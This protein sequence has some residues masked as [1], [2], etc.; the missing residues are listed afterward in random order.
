[1][2]Q[3]IAEGVEPAVVVGRA[4]LVV[5]IEV[6][7]VGKLGTL[8]SARDAV[9]ARRLD[10]AEGTAERQQALVVERLP[11]QDQHG[12]AVDALGQRL[13]CFGGEG[14]G[15][16]DP[17][18]LGD[19][20]RLPLLKT[21]RH[22]LLRRALARRPSRGPDVLRAEPSRAAPLPATV[23]VDD[24]ARQIVHL[25]RTQHGS[26]RRDLLRRFDPAEGEP[27]GIEIRAE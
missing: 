1:M 4:H 21:K 14:C 15:E 19:E 6:G 23:H 3:A 12:I 20:I 9:V 27:L 25:R 18:Y 17:A 26:Q 5:G 22:L 16:V 10:V 8:Q 24:R 7:D 13:A 2:P 11:T